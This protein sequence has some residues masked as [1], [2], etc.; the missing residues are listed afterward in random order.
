MI[1]YRVKKNTR[2]GVFL[3]VFVSLVLIF[4]SCEL[5]DTSSDDAVAPDTTA[6]TVITLVPANDAT[7]VSAAIT[8]ITVT[9]SEAMG[10]GVTLSNPGINTL[11]S[12]G[13]PSWNS[14]T[15]VRIPVTLA[16]DTIYSLRLNSTTYQSFKDASGNAL[17]PV[18][19]TFTTAP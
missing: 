12:F 9:F 2:Y 5:E 10:T 6:P 17:V 3:L 15:T 14:V 7:G 1:S 11:P 4:S 8:E 18:L 13:I 16:A 19:W